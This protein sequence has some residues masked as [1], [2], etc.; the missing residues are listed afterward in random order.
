MHRL[1]QW[2]SVAPAP[3]AAAGREFGLDAEQAGQAAAM[4][5]AILQ[6]QGAWAWNPAVI[7]FAA[8][9]IELLHQGSLLRIDRLVQRCDPGHQ[10]EWW[11]LDYKSALDPQSQP[12]LLAQLS[13][14]RDAV[15]LIHPDQ[16]VKAAFL[17]AAGDMQ[18]LD[19]AEA[20]PS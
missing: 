7:A 1:L 15:Q 4:A 13:A 3:V 14:Y 20:S 5:Q 17:T 6:G 9:E 2:N 10:G 12:G 11:V 8:D 19:P 18:V 16:A